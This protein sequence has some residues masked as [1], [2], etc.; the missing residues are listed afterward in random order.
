M[1][2]DFPY[3]R[4]N[5]EEILKEKDSWALNKEEFEIN[6]E[7]KKE[8]I[9][10]LFDVNQ[11]VFSIPKSSNSLLNHH[12]IDNKL[13]TKILFNKLNDYFKRYN[14]IS[15]IFGKLIEFEDSFVKMVSIQKI[16]KK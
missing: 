8:L 7:L 6:N 16:F 12:K 10:K 13:T 4:P 5:C 2:S 1:S 14:E 3:K 15:L 9:N 11:I